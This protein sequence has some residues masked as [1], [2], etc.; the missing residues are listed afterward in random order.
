MVEYKLPSNQNNPF[1]FLEFELIW[2]VTTSPVAFHINVRNPSHQSVLISCTH[3]IGCWVVDVYVRI[4]LKCLKF[5]SSHVQETYYNFNE[6]KWPG[7]QTKSHII[8]QLIPIEDMCE[9][10]TLFNYF[11]KKYDHSINS[12]KM[13]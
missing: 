6:S 9:L 7:L 1:V 4:I 3:S 12:N 11:C 10:I 2:W 8:I 5:S 13:L